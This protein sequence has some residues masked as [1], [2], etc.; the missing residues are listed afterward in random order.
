MLFCLTTFFKI[1]FRLLG[2]IWVQTV[3]QSYQQTTPA[4][5]ELTTFFFL[6]LGMVH[7]VYIGMSGNDFQKI[8]LCL[9][10]NLFYLNSVDPDEMLHHAAFHLGL[11]CL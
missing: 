8:L 4:C 10:E 5:N 7:C 6:I 2:L 9:T 1:S 3:C 11:H